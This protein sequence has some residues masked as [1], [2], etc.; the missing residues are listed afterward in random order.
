MS[1]EQFDVIVIGGGSAGCVAA[2]RLSDDPARRVLL[3]EEGDDPQPVPDVIANPKRQGELILSSPYIRQYDVER[4]DGSWFAL[5]SGKVLGGGSSVNNIAVMR[6]LRRDFDDWVRFGGE[7]WS[8]DACLPIMIALEDDPT[9]ADSP[10]HG[11]DGPL[12]LMRRW[13][14]EG[15]ADPPV[16]A[17]I[18]AARD[19]GIPECPDLNVPDAYGLCASPYTIIDGKRQSAVNA[20]LDPIRDRPNLVIRAETVATRLLVDGTRVTGVELQGPDGTRTTVDAVRVVVSAGAYHSPH[21][22]LNSGIGPAD[23]LDPVGIPVRHE[24]AGVGENF[25]DHAVVYLT[26]Q[27][28]ENLKQEYLIPKV[29][30]FVASNP[31]LDHGD[32][33][34][35]MHPSIAMEGMPPLLP[36]SVRLLEDRSPGRISLASDD[37]LELPVVDPGILRHPTD[38]AA[39]MGGIRIVEQVVTHPAMAKFY[40]PLVT[41]SSPDEYEEHIVSSHITYNHAVG[42]CRM[43]PASDP[44]AVVDPELRVH[45][46]D[47][48]WVADCSVLPSLPH[49][50]TNL[51][52]NMIGII[53]A[54]NIAAAG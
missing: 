1:N 37:P 45:G 5:V 2:A 22:L 43:G 39:V 25:Q 8:Y 14:L 17:L 51:A 41:P 34:I 10:I 50:Q 21:L 44:L 38:V 46:L 16:R 31:S 6:P 23:K 47:N 15:E 33:H 42:T 3:V 40:G 28:T 13:T 36:V 26:Y 54:R 27:G 7:T 24:L 18:E 53:V 35:L 29:R 49:C 19:L 20:F 11:T 48:L 52:A 32:L 30:L 9:Y 4:P 12:K